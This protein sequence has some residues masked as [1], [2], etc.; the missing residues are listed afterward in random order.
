[1]KQEMVG[2]SNQLKG[3]AST[4]LVFDQRHGV[5]MNRPIE[6]HLELRKFSMPMS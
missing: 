5:G 6:R 3:G 4:P 1:M 2:Q